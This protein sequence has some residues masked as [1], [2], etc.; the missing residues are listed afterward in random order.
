MRERRTSNRDKKTKI[1]IT[2]T[3]RI[4]DKK[5]PKGGKKANNWGSGG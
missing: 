4:R 3:A 2:A 1:N 5:N